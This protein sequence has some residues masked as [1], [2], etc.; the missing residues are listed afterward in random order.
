MGIY[1]YL[2][3]LSNL[4]VSRNYKEWSL[5]TFP[6][7][8]SWY[9]SSTKSMAGAV[10]SCTVLPFCYI[11]YEFWVALFILK[12]K[13][14]QLA[15]NF[16]SFFFRFLFF[17][18]LFFFLEKFKSTHSLVWKVRFFFPAT[19]KKTAFLLTHLI[20]PQKSKKTNYTL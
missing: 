9:F 18:V 16:Y 1:S 3:Y 10:R 2:Q 7:N 12:G 15:M 11:G 20:F 13:K 6:I 5:C 19:K 8:S 4:N 14:P 17:L